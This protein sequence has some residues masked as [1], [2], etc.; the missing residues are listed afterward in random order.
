MRFAILGGLVCLA[1]A[2][3]MSG[4]GR[5]TRILVLAPATPRAAR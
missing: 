2:S 5:K 4:E 3:L 1:A